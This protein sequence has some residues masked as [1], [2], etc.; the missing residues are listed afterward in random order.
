MSLDMCQC[1]IISCNS[2]VKVNVDPMYIRR[3]SQVTCWIG[4]WSFQ[5]VLCATVNVRCFE[6][7][8]SVI[9]AVPS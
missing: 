9:L 2:N 3:H 6:N 7:I 4:E 1:D 5:R 8:W